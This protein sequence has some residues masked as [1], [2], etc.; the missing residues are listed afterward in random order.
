MHQTKKTM[1]IWMYLGYLSS[2]ECPPA[3]FGFV[4]GP[5]PLKKWIDSFRLN[6]LGGD[7]ADL[8]MS[9]LGPIPS[10]V[11][12]CLSPIPTDRQL[13]PPNATSHLRWPASGCRFLEMH[14][15]YRE[16]RGRP[17]ARLAP[18]VHFPFWN[19]A[20]PG[21]DRKRQVRRPGP[22]PVD[23]AAGRSPTGG[24]ATKVLLAG[25]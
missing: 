23:L 9:T 18:S 8:G 2:M 15:P 10:C 22:I 19:F 7:Y 17:S 13:K 6:Q 4:L 1:K 12:F 20:L 24:Q 14:H 3:S 25:L 5:S 16:E 21:G 11:R